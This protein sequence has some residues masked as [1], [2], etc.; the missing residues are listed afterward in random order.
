MPEMVMGETIERDGPRGGD[1][2]GDIAGLQ[3]QFDLLRYMRRISQA[4]GFKS[5]MICHL[6][7]FDGEKLA[8]NS[9]L[10]N[11]PAELV[12][13][14]DS[15]AMAHYSVGVR[16]LRETTTPFRIT[17]EDWEREN[18]SSP[19]WWNISPCWASRGSPRRTIFPSTTPTAGALR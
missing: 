14:Y 2:A 18:E 13:K 12:S 16:R 8:A 19:A 1:F 15:L 5:F 7:S 10:S 6:P 3:T 9:L 4:F 17:V 11:M